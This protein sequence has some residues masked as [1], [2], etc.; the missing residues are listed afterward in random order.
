MSKKDTEFGSDLI[1]ALIEVRAHRRSE[2]ALPS[3]KED[4]NS[5]RR[6]KAI[7]T[8]LVKAPKNFETT[9]ASPPVSL[10]PTL[11]RTESKSKFVNKR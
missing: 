4:K 6:D 7:R 10:E 8:T 1:Q 3:R 5:A 2:I 9:V 11:E